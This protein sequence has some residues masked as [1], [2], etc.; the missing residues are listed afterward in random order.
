LSIALYS[1]T[2]VVNVN[3]KCYLFFFTT[4]AINMLMTTLAN[5][6]RAR[7]AEL[8]ITQEELA[9]LVGVSQT[10]IFK[11]VAGQTL[12]PR[13]LL[14]LAKALKVSPQWLSTG[15]D[16]Q[17]SSVNQPQESNAHETFDLGAFKHVP[18][19]GHTQLGDNG[20]WS[21]LEFPVGFGDGCIPFP[22][23][24]ANAY[25]LRC[26]GDSMRP[27]IKSGEYVI[28]APNT[29]P[30]SGDEVLI[31]SS[32]GRVMVKTLLY[33]RDGRLHVM[34]INEA[35]PPQSFNLDEV[36]KIHVVAAIVKQSMLVKC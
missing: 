34:S 36:E 29:E 1:I 26:V 32:D 9:K 16:T 27:R 12:E 21:E 8:S 7:M 25:A 2:F 15:V 3:N 4:E 20:H 19:V 33:T 23:A 18:V 30:V 35:H 31:R 28:I 14:A 13:K 11:I 17:L 5:R 24:D 10:A 6:V 22:I